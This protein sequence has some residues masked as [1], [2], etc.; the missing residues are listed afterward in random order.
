MRGE[1]AVTQGGGDAP[2][3][4]PKVSWEEQ[5]LA[6]EEQRP[7]DNP[8]RN[9]PPPPPQNTLSASITTPLVAPSTSDDGFTIVQEQKSR[10]K[11]APKGGPRR[12]PSHPFPSTE[13]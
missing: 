10:D 4:C 9:L 2:L 11:R 8:K 5:V 7:K 6:E 1:T 3:G 12:S 13:E